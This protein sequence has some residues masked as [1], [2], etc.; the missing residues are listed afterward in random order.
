MFKVSWSLDSRVDQAVLSVRARAE[1]AKLATRLA[2]LEE[3]RRR[4]RKDTRK[5]EESIKVTEKGVETNSPYAKFMEYGTVY[6]P[7]RPFMRPAA[8]IGRVVFGREATD[9]IR[10]GCGE[11]HAKAKPPS[12]GGAS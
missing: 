7:A 6:V 12:E 5:L 2:I 1:A 3:A 9:Q 10:Q 4:V 8:E 11:I